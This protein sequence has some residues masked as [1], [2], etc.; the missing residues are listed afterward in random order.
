MVSADFGYKLA[1]QTYADEDATRKGF[2]P[3]LGFLTLVVILFG[4]LYGG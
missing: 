2:I 4:W 3:L 1:Q